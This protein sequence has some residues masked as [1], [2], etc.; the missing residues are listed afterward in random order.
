MSRRRRERAN[1]AHPRKVAEEVQE[2]VKLQ[3]KC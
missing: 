1:V 2:E 3:L